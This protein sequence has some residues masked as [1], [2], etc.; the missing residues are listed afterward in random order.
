MEAQ[1]GLARWV[2]CVGELAV[3]GTPALEHGTECWNLALARRLGST[4]AVA[5]MFAATLSTPF[6]LDH[7]TIK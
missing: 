3:C 5:L 2:V 6:D 4:P 1:R 7:M